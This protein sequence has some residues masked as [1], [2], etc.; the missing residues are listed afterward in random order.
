MKSK[1][2]TTCARANLSEIRRF[3][4][5]TLATLDV[6]ESVKQE[7]ILAVDEA[8]ANAIIHGNQCDIQKP[9]LIEVETD[10]NNLIVEISDVGNVTEAE[11]HEHKEKSLEDL[12]EERSNGGLGLKLIYSLMDEVSYF[13]R[14]D[15][16]ICS[17]RKKI[18]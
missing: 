7:I 17:L 9:L 14:D 1:F 2:T 8:C 4:H 6:A 5:K 10:E 11:L 15:K 12:V 18:G 13:S 3:L 16:H